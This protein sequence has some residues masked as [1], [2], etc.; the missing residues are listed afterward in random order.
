MVMVVG[1][2][3]TV[4]KLQQCHDEGILFIVYSFLY[5]PT[6]QTPDPS[7]ISYFRLQQIGLTPAAVMAVTRSAEAP[8]MLLLPMIASPVFVG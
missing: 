1:D 7:D 5:W 3:A 2:S 8:S 6:L 4:I